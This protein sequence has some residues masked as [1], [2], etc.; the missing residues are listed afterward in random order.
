[1]IREPKDCAS[2]GALRAEIDRID[3]ELVALLARRV[4]C[5]DRAVELKG[6]Q[7]LPARIDARVEEVAGRARAAAE[8]RGLDA[9]FIEALWRRIIEWSIAREERA[10]GGKGRE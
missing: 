10:L 4:A 8:A 5:I 9:D 3:R 2:M 1:M 6:A 7:G